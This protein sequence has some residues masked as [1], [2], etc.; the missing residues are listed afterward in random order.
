MTLFDILKDIITFKSGTLHEKPEFKKSFDKF[1]IMRFLSMHPSSF[2]V[3]E[4]LNIYAKQ[5][6]IT[7]EDFYLIL[8]DKVP[9]SRNNFIKY[10]K[11]PKPPKVETED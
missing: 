10:I 2:K 11:K 6:D 3:V 1:I 9:Y 5:R 8:V 4:E 7:D